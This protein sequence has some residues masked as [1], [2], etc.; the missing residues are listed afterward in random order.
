MLQG[1]RATRSCLYP[2]WSYWARRQFFTV[3]ET[4]LHFPCLSGTGRGCSRLLSILQTDSL[5]GR[6]WELLSFG[7]ELIPLSVHCMGML[8]ASLPNTGFALR[9]INF[10]YLCLSWSATGLCCFQLL[11]A[12][13]VS[14]G[15]K[16]LFVV[17][18]AVI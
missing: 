1:H 8:Y 7:C 17:S 15:Q 5:V 18:G 10:A 2:Y 9:V 13:L 6:G 16:T 4:V 14:W 3:G 12:L 11:P